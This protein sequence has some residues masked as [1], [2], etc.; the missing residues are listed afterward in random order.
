MKIKTNRYLN[1]LEPKYRSHQSKLLSFEEPKF[2][3]D[4]IQIQD[5]EGAKPRKIMS[6]W[7]GRETNKKDGIPNTS[8]RKPYVRGTQ[9]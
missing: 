4:N 9:Y 6:K 7:Q 8:P 1:P 2:I 3:R 5:I